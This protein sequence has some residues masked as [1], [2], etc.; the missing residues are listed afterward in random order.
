MLTSS[1]SELI[2][3][4]MGES[5]PST[6]ISKAERAPS[7]SVKA[8]RRRGKRGGKRER[9]RRAKRAQRG[10][11]A[12]ANKAPSAQVYVLVEVG[13]RCYVHNSDPSGVWPPPREEIVGTRQ[14]LVLFSDGHQQLIC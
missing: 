14:P 3:E 5:Q 7:P 6:N 8:R 4:V 12:K 2:R 10:N 13:G 11:V 1:H 9:L